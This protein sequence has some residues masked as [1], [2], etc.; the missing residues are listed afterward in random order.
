MFFYILYKLGYYLSNILPLKAAY[1]TA[2]RCSDIHYFVSKKDRD[3][4]TQNLSIVLKKDKRECRALAQKVFRNFGLYLVD[5]FRM[6]RLSK[7]VIEKKVEVQGME[8]LKEA[9]S[10][11]RGAIALTCHIGNW[12]MGGVSVGIM[13][14]NIAAVALV[15]KYKKI[16]DFF[17]KQREENGM[18]VIN[19]T[20]IMKRCISLLL[21]NGILALAGDRDFT[22]SGIMLDFFGV[23]TSIPKGAVMLSL[24]VGSPIVP[25]FFLRKD[26]FY[27]KLIFD[28]PIEV[29]NIPGVDVTDKDEI[30]KRT[31]RKFVSKMEEYIRA[32][33]DQWLVFRKF[34]ETPTD[35]FVL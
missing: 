17:T 19:I 29:K 24:K 26:R 27:Y 12:E 4:V 10:K 28:K 22:N 21:D 20:S 14:Y 7:S 35:A 18:N 34:W 8:N 11:N 13:G 31:M 3:A 16:N 25:T 32:Y 6:H 9:L 1:V 15:H 33:P 23:P 2:E 5:F 30:I